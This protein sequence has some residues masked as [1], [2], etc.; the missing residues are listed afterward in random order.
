MTSNNGGGHKGYKFSHEVKCGREEWDKMQLL[1]FRN[2][3]E[4]FD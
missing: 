1:D 4:W 3:E 2:E